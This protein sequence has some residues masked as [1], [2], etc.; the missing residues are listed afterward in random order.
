[1]TRV[2]A[3]LQ[4]AGLEALIT[5]IVT[6]LERRIRKKAGPPPL[7]ERSDQRRGRM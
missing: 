1:V 3:R 2:A 7:K 4:R 6:V 5:V